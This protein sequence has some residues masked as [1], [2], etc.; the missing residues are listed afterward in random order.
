MFAMRLPL[1][2]L[3]S[4]LFSTTLLGFESQHQ[5]AVGAGKVAG[6]LTAPNANYRAMAFVIIAGSGPT[7]RDGN[8]SILPGKN[9]SLKYLAEDL[10]AK[11]FAAFRYDKPGIAESAQ[12]WNPEALKFSDMVSAAEQVVD[13]LKTE[14]G[15]EKVVVIGHSEGA[16]IGLLASQKKADGYVSL[17][18]PARNAADLLKQQLAQL[19]PT[20][21]EKAFA[22]LDSLQMGFPV[23]NDIQSLQ[24]IFYLQVQPY[25]VEWFQYNPCMLMATNTLPT[26]IV[27]GTEDLQVP[28]AEGELLQQCAPKAT[29]LELMYM[30]HV[31]KVV[32]E[33]DAADNQKAYSDP[34]LPLHPGLVAGIIKKFK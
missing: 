20:T 25:L 8:S 4:M 13:Y 34:T 16:L 1:C 28:T 26:L 3:F 14:L 12:W 30:N 6:T 19:D 24:S 15:F 32:E 10:T 2:I 17:A 9:N 29:Y 21:K 33:G 11:G 7:D 5:I 18:G 23:A 22:K 31:L 27:Q